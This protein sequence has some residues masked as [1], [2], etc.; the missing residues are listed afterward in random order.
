MN[1]SRFVQCD[2]SKCSGC[3][4]CAAI[5]P[6][7]AIEMK[8]DEYGYIYPIIDEAVCIHCNKCVN[9]CVLSCSHDFKLPIATYAG[10]RDD[11]KKLKLSSSGGVFAAV[12]EHIIDMDGY[13]CGAKI[14]DDFSVSHTIVSRK[15]ALAPLLGSKYVQSDILS[16][17]DPIKKLI[18]DG[19]TVLFSG[20]PCQVMAMKKYIGSSEL[21]ITMEVIC[22]GVPN[23]EMFRGYVKMLSKKNVKKFYFRDKSQGWSFNHKVIYADGSVKK[24]NH[25]LSSYMTLF[26]KGCI[27][28]ESCFSCPYAQARRNADIT[29]GDFWGVVR[30]RPDLEKK[31]KIDDGVSCVI[32]NTEKGN[33]I[34]SNSDIALYPVNYL[35]ITDGNGPLNNPSSKAFNYSEVLRIWKENHSWVDVNDYWKRKYYKIKYRLWALMP[36]SLRNRIR[37]IMKVR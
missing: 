34:L 2:M 33:Q 16:V 4:L 9:S 21:L 22:H 29:I 20:T 11:K 27:Y 37:I 6:V 1:K 24:I 5:C 7:K 19:K 10:V 12:A 13:V 36:N 14:N 28:R 17:F 18:S 30:K 15:S 31:L 23:Q 8:P 32:I 3:G 35:D 26:M 25:R